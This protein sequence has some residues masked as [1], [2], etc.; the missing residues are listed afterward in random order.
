MTIST[1]VIL[2]K[3]QTEDYVPLK[4][5]VASLDSGYSVR[6]GG[7]VSVDWSLGEPLYDDHVCKGWVHRS[8]FSDRNSDFVFDFIKYDLVKRLLSGRIFQNWCQIRTQTL[9]T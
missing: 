3:C 4:E 5:V 6:M 1:L 8:S 2:V 9:Q 7:I